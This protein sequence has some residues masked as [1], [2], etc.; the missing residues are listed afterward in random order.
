MAGLNQSF[1]H[2]T[3]VM[4]V[5]EIVSSYEMFGLTKDELEEVRSIADNYTCDLEESY[6]KDELAGMFMAGYMFARYYDRN[7]DFAQLLPND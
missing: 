2:H 1:M 5:G 6:E 4:S 7:K 3:D